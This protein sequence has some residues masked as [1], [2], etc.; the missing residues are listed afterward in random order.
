MYASG[1]TNL[2]ADELSSLLDHAPRVLLV[3]RKATGDYDLQMVTK[4]TSNKSSAVKRR[5]QRLPNAATTEQVAAAAR[6]QGVGWVAPTVHAGH[7]VELAQIAHELGLIY[8]SP[9]TVDIVEDKWKFHELLAAGGLATRETFPCTTHAQIGQALRRMPSRYCV[10]KARDGAHSGI[11]Q[12]LVDT[13]CSKRA[14]DEIINAHLAARDAAGYHKTL[15]QDY[16]DGTEYGF[17]GLVATIESKAELVWYLTTHKHKTP[18]PATKLISHVYD[19]AD[20]SRLADTGQL[21]VPAIKR[22]I[23]LLDA[24]DRDQRG[25]PNCPINADIRVSGGQ[26]YVIDVS[27]RWAPRFQRLA[28]ATLGRS[29]ND[30]FFPQLA[31]EWARSAHPSTSGLKPIGLPRAA[32]IQK[33]FNNGG[34]LAQERP[35]VTTFGKNVFYA[36]IPEPGR[37]IPSAYDTTATGDWTSYPQVCADGEDLASAERNWNRAMEQSGLAAI[38]EGKK[39]TYDSSGLT[40]QKAPASR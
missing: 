19:P 14:I 33:A 25:L 21:V 7:T 15:V 29:C 11:S 30:P 38:K 8:P 2:D 35:R 31:V 9:R 17:Q 27:L 12:K 20:Q 32:I 24:T 40:K 5:L 1:F 13:T 23:D 22:I 28:N 37:E 26:A 18:L 39:Y 10:L 6:K 4:D 36:D 34:L 16:I 3:T